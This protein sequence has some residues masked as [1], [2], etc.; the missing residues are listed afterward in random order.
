MNKEK[1]KRTRVVAYFLLGLSIVN[2]A[3][4]IAKSLFADTDPSPALLV[5][6]MATLIVGSIGLARAKKASQERLD[7]RAA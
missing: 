5:T 6:G 7:R 4:Y 3:L 1:A 2:L